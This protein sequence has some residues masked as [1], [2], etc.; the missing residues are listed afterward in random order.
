MSV[1]ENVTLCIVG[2]CTVEMDEI[3]LYS[4]EDKV[5]LDASVSW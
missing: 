1:D 4:K 3:E 5:N 2:E